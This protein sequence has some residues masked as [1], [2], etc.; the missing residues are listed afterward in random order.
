MTSM[1]HEGSRSLQDR[2][3]TRRLADRIEVPEAA[4]RGD[5]S[6]SWCVVSYIPQVGAACGCEGGGSGLSA[7]HRASLMTSSAGGYRVFLRT[8]TAV[9]PRILAGVFLVRLRPEPTQ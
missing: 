3:D 2:F 4:P 7:C 9:F 5:S 6:D 1:F 8:R